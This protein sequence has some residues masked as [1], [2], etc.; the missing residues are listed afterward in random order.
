MKWRD[1]TDLRPV[2]MKPLIGNVADWST[3]AGIIERRI[4]PSIDTYGPTIFQ[5]NLLP[6]PEGAVVPAVEDLSSTPWKNRYPI[7]AYVVTGICQMIFE[8]HWLSVPAGQGVFIPANTEYAGHACIKGE[9]V[10]CDVLW[11]S[12]FPFGALVHRCQLSPIEHLG[13]IPYTVMNPLLWDIVCAL[14][15][16][17]KS[18]LTYHLRLTAKG[19]LLSFFSLLLQSPVLQLMPEDTIL[20]EQWR[21]FPTPLRRALRWIHFSFH[22][23]FRLDVLAHFCAVSPAYLCRLFKSYLGMTPTNYLRQLRLQVAYRLLEA[24]DLSVVDIAFL[25]GFKNF[26]YF[27]RQFRKFFGHS[28]T[29]LR[30]RIPSRSTPVTRHPIRGARPRS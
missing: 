4:L 20:T 9:I 17:L 11:F 18:S 30:R 12:V 7:F 2:P 25:V 19:L 14:S 29:Q 23:P 5:P 1:G 28:P 26:P 10:P 8:G 21:N 15:N 6:L 13:S 16:F 27:V 22:K 24:T 3:F